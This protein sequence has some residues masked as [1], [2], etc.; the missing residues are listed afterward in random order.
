[1]NARDYHDR[2]K[3][4]VAS[5]RANRHMLDWSIEPLPFKIYTTLEPLPLPADVA[6]TEVPALAAIGAGCAPGAAPVD[7][8][9]LARL[10]R[11]SAGIIRTR[12]YPGGQIRHFRAA[13]CTGALYHIDLYLVCGDLPGLAAGVY[14]FGPHDFALRRL[15]AGDHRAVLVQATGDE[16]R[17]ASAPAVLVCTS[18]FWRNAWKYQ[19]RTYRHC[20]WDCG[21]ILAN[22]LAVAAADRIAAEVV[23]GFADAIVNQLLALDIQR[24]VALAIVP[25]G[26][27]AAPPAGAPALGPLALAT[28]PLSAREVDYPLIH[29]AHA[30]TALPDPAAVRSW[31]A[32][33]QATP[34]PRA[35]SD[36]GACPPVELRSLAQPPPATIDDVIL[37]R[38]SARRFSR[39]AID[40]GALWSML[41]AATRGVPFDF[42]RPDCRAV[43]EPYLIVNAVDGLTPGA[44]AL[45]ADGNRLG[46]LKQGDFRRE[47]GFLDLGQDLAADAAVN[48]YLLAD[49]DRILSAQGDR[50]YRAAQLDGAI[51]GGKL[52]LAAYAL[53]LGATGLTFFDDDV[54]GFFSPHAAGKAVMFL[55]AIGKRARRGG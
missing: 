5:L 49:L 40:L 18:T 42:N 7:L 15:R 25:L 13:A 34:A 4:S 51:I 2:T 22:L 6:A 30:A 17:V 16:P 53:G 12:R 52:Y 20:F 29:A 10:L 11:L 19:A 39:A 45:N 24:E 9:Q 31:R 32:H 27:G 43:V 54:T 21:T 44:Y 35:S 46:C 41:R 28:E 33:A 37:R 3:H 50:G 1:M 8:R 26:T 55:M 47:A 48:V 23:I 14:H 36:P 38:G